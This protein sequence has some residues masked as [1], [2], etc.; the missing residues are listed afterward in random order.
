MIRECASN[1]SENNKKIE[2]KIENINFAKRNNICNKLHLLNIEN[3]KE[4]IGKSK[5]FSENFELL[6]YIDY[7]SE[8]LVFNCL[9]KNQRKQLISKIIFNKEKGKINK[10]ELEILFK[11]RHKNIITFYSY[12][13]IIKGESWL[14]IMEDAKL[15]NLSNFKRYILSISQSLNE[16]LICY[17]ASQIFDGII[18][19][20]NCKI[21]HMDLKPKNIVIDEFLNIKIIDFSI[22]IDYKDKKQN[23]VIKLPFLGTSYYMPIE[24]LATQ[25]IKYKDIHKID[26]YSFGVILFNLAFG[27]FPYNITYDDE[28]DYYKI[29]QKI[30]INDIDIEKNNNGFSSYFI[31]FLKKLL[32]KDIN[33][34]MNI[35]EA[36]NH[37]WIKGSKIL[38]DEK[39][40]IG[41]T[42]IFFY[43][44][45][46]NN[47][48][49]FNA[50]IKQ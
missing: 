39:E 41:N 7:G 35:T 17:I 28:E 47:I 3:I 12:S 24:I 45:I 44:I 21:A 31:D 5:Y 13:H 40:K 9:L 19:L 1:Q 20:Y 23:D 14:M 49:D 33:E 36:K 46:T 27:K 48:K 29:Y 18:Y 11:L 32:K 4:Y 16:S 30:Y 34:R 2:I 22:S 42:N 37:Y 15:G 50:Y 10:R 6:K 26:L 25:K 43:N 38:L 8:S